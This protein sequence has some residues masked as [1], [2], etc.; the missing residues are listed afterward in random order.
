MICNYFVKL[1]GLSVTMKQ[2]ISN[3]TCTPI[4]RHCFLIYSQF[5]ITKLFMIVQ[6]KGNEECNLFG[7]K[8]IGGERLIN[9]S[10]WD[11]VLHLAQEARLYQC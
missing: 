9:H 5:R 8:N 1:I 10:L 4:Y 3:K 6:Q 7:S 2:Y 11:Y